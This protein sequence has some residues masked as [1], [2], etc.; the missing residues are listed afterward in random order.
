MGSLIGLSVRHSF[1]IDEF[2]FGIAGARLL[3]ETL[4]ERV[5]SVDNRFEGL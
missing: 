1:T 5:Y 2:A 3:P 4:P